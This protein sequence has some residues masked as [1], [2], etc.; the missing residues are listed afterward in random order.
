MWS[1]RERFDLGDGL[2]GKDLISSQSQCHL[3]YFRRFLPLLSFEFFG[4][5]TG[6]GVF[7]FGLIQKFKFNIHLNLV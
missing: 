6:S 3:R 2:I 7:D 5:Y 4:I 1:D